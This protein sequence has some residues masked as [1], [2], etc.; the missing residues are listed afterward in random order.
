MRIYFTLTKPEIDAA[1]KAAV[2]KTR[3]PGLKLLKAPAAAGVTHGKM[4]F[5]VPRTSGKAHD[6]NNLDAALNQSFIRKKF[7]KNRQS[8]LSSPIPRRSLRLR[9]T[10]KLFCYHTDEI[11]MIK[12]LRLWITIFL[13]APIA[14]SAHFW[15]RITSAFT[16]SPVATMRAPCSTKNHGI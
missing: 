13:K 7:L 11:T 8:G 4:L 2:L 16:R 3:G 15:D 9:Y 12:R 14:W 6:R 5:I 10:Q 1:F